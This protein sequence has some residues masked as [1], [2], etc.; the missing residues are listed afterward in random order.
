MLHSSL[1]S[2]LV[3]LFQLF[4]PVLCVNALPPWGLGPGFQ[5]G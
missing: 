2:L 3:S 1:A 5:E 4:Q